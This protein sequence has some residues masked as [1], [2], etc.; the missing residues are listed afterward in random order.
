MKGRITMWLRRLRSTRG[1]TMTETLLG[2]AV[3]GLLVMGVCSA[4]VNSS[5]STK[6]TDVVE[7]FDNSNQNA[8]AAFRS[9]AKKAVL[10]SN[11]LPAPF[12]GMDRTING[13]TIVF[14]GFYDNNLKKTTESQA[15]YKVQ[16]TAS[17]MATERYGFD[18]TESEVQLDI[19]N[20]EKSKANGWVLR[21]HN[22]NMGDSVGSSSATTVRVLSLNDDATVADLD[23]KAPEI[24]P[25]IPIKPEDWQTITLKANLTGQRN[26]WDITKS[27]VNFK[28]VGGRLTLVSSA[29]VVTAALT[30]EQDV[31]EKTAPLDSVNNLKNQVGSKPT[32][33]V[34]EIYYDYVNL[35][36]LISV[37][38]YTLINPV[39]N[40]N[41]SGCFTG[42]G[43]TFTP[44]T[45]AA[46]TLRNIL[47][48]KYATHMTLTLVPKP[49]E[50]SPAEG[51][52]TDTKYAVRLFLPGG[53]S[54][55]PHTIALKKNGVEGGKLYYR[56]EIYD[57][58]GKNLMD[59]GNN[60]YFG[61]GAHVV[62]KV[63]FG[64]GEKE[65]DNVT[66]YFYQDNGHT[67]KGSSP[68]TARGWTRTISWEED[69]YFGIFY[70][71]KKTVTKDV[72]GE[73][74]E[75]T[76]MTATNSDVQI[77]RVFVSE[78]VS[79]KTQPTHSSGF[80]WMS[81][82][83]GWWT[84]T[85]TAFGDVVNNGDLT[86]IQGNTEPQYLEKWKNAMNS[87]SNLEGQGL[88]P[89]MITVKK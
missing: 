36:N 19:A 38:G 63:Y 71:G 25:L 27:K 30:S 46:E 45:N 26:Y 12:N 87:V 84:G 28:D 85:G 6:E 72:R 8:I 34:V 56:I 69:V 49:R 32:N 59:T 16:Y 68:V 15:A 3:T 83:G 81:D 82:N 39:G 4:V 17:F 18:F 67:L 5:A 76:G 11:A 7:F 53:Y 77:D 31:R 44:D 89:N 54:N 80:L 48:I 74:T 40:K 60:S 51:K 29:E 13:N 43:A 42:T 64:F 9:N 2:M 61:S 55:G 22:Q 24:E 57:R 47:G 35:K 33:I 65:V 37:N 23:P 62:N 14:T 66:F 20:Y 1:F 70:Q 52:I 73:I 21:E 86:W 58:N 50:V 10:T 79:D 75:Y 78:V 41:I 88:L